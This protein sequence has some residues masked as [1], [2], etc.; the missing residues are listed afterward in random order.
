MGFEGV[1][2]LS[3]PA[4]QVKTGVLKKRFV[5][6]KPANWIIG[7]LIGFQLM[8]YSP[9]LFAN[10]ANVQY[11]VDESRLKI[12][13]AWKAPISFTA[14]VEKKSLLPVRLNEQNAVVNTE[15]NI[16]LEGRDLLIRFDQA[17]DF[18]DLEILA[19]EIDSW[20]ESMNTGYDTLLIRTRAPAFFK[21]LS[22]PEK[23]IV[24]IK[25]MRE[26]S[27]VEG[28]DQTAM[29]ISFLETALDLNRP[30]AIASILEKYGRDFLSSRPLLAAKLM[31]KLNDR[32]STLYWV[33]KAE[34]I[35]NLNFDQQIDLM[36]LY[37]KLELTG[38]AKDKLNIQELG[39]LIM[40]KMGQS[41]V[42]E[43]RKKDFLYTLLDLNLKEEALPYLKNFAHSGES[44]WVSA[45]EETLKKLERTEELAQFWRE[46]SRQSNVSDEDKRNIAFQFLELNRKKDAKRIFMDLA[47]NASP[48]HPDVLQ[49]LYLWGPAA[50]RQSRE[51]L[52]SRAKAS[53]GEEL[54]QWM[55]HLISAGAVR[56]AVDVTEKVSSL[57]NPRVF[58]AYL[59]AL[60]LLED[61]AH[62]TASLEK[63]LRSET[64]PDRLY[65]LGKL[66]EST[67]QY[68]VAEAAFRKV[69]KVRP[70]DP[71]TVKAMGL[72][73]Y[74]QNH[75][76]EAETYLERYL[77]LG[78]GDWETHYYY[79][80]TSHSLNKDSVAQD[81]YSR[82]L[83]QI[84]AFSQKSY[85]MRMAQ[86]RCLQRLGRKKDA[87]KVFEQLISQNPG[88][89]RVRAD[90]I[91]ALMEFGD[92]SRAEELLKAN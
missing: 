10:E 20:I 30:D 74:Y 2:I 42:P 70:E 66:A 31:E 88:D 22:D 18:Q 25:A 40:K 47:R 62:V 92:I 7:F 68:A 79:A 57:D 17:V 52:V 13:L 59:E 60:E 19:K 24:E 6:V 11:Q 49:L 82:A 3:R 85:G 87:V 90:F 28:L 55:R 21:I 91:A 23:I 39:N 34:S 35:Q 15:S 77:N 81:N 8:G 45:Y 5:L 46:R 76:E 56:E 14:W 80:E 50:D 38:R 36:S 73:S 84:E 44:D 4:M 75:W 1:K 26:M 37:S 63:R 58:A 61:K 33:E 86:A 67:E 71:R 53:R 54:A 27:P 65:G 78:Q 48:E 43:Q 29:L 72:I 32:E 89:K 12:I 51:W 9:C 69:L 83:Q 16:P 41:S 64:D